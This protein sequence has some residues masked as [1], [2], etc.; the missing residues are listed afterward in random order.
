MARVSRKAG[1]LRVYG[2][3]HHGPGCARSLVAALDAFQPDAVLVEGP[4]EG[5]ALLP[6]VLHPAMRPPVALLLYRPERPGAATWYPFQTWSPEWQALRWA[7]RSGAAACFFD[8]PHRHR[9]ALAEEGHRLAGVGDGLS[10]LARAGGEEDPE[11]WWERQVEER[12]QDEGLFEAIA[13]AMGALREGQ[14]L[15]PSRLEAAREAHMRQQLREARRKHRRVAAVCGAWHVPALAWERPAEDD[16]ALLRGLPRVKILATWAPWTNAR[17]AQ[18]SGYGAGVVSP[19]WFAHLWER[20]FEADSAWL[21][22]AAGL[23]RAQGHDTSADHV[24]AGTRL[25]RALA[26]LRQRPGPGREELEEAILSV[27]C[28]GD[29]APMRSIRRALEVGE[30][31]GEVPPEA[32]APPLKQDLDQTLRALRLSARVSSAPQ[33]L[34]L[35]LRRDLDRAR[36]ELLHRLAVLDL[37]WGKRQR[38]SGRELG[39]FREGWT[40]RWDVEFTVR[41]LEASTWGNTLEEA[42]TARACAD[43]QRTGALPELTARLEQ[44]LL[45]NLPRAIGALLDALRSRAALTSDLDPLLQAL[46]PLARIARYGDARRTPPEQLEPT[47]DGLFERVVVGLGPACRSLDAD[48]AESR[49]RGLEGLHEALTHLER[50][51]RMAEWLDALRELGADEGA[52]ALLRGRAARLLADGQQ[53]DPDALGRLARVNLSAARPAADAAAWLEGVVRGSGSVLLHLDALWAA[54][55]SWLDGLPE[56]HFVALLPVARRAFSTF[57]VAERRQM[58]HKVQSLGRTASGGQALEGEATVDAR[59]AAAVLPALAEVLGSRPG[60]HHVG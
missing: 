45:A 54:L 39:S 38:G 58:A 55:D 60:A 21:S 13:E 27:L 4:P 47:F 56:E 11:L 40:L 22:Q 43:A 48:A 57:S 25:A 32:P 10:G 18:E 9:A 36:S 49:C 1:E 46:P 52:H 30:V 12:G 7:L 41:V 31:I 51:E 23:L 8:L 3:R 34:A 53:L 35:D 33:E 15:P 16:A 2:V 50:P 5:D 37:P 59:R 20:G 42:A 17:L 26:A 6:L 44:A 14:L 28:H 19:A 24:I 29:P